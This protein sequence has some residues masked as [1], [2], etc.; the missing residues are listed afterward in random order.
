MGLLRNI[1]NIV[2]LP[3]IT[4]TLSSVAFGAV[5]TTP[6]SKSVGDALDVLAAS[7]T[8]PASLVAVNANIAALAN[9]N[10]RNRELY[11]LAPE[12]N[13]ALTETSQLTFIRGMHPVHHRFD[14]FGGYAAGVPIAPD[15]AM[16]MQVQGHMAKQ[17]PKDEFAGFHA[18]STGVEIGLEKIFEKQNKVGVD[19]SFLSSGTDPR[20]FAISENDTDSYQVDLY[21][22]YDFEALPIYIAANFSTAF[23]Q[24]HTRRHI[25]AGGAQRDSKSSYHGWQAGSR[26]ELG[27]MWGKE[28]I[29]I[30]PVVGATYVHTHF[31]NYRETSA[32]FLNL[33]VK[34][35]DTN[36]FRTTVGFRS[37]YEGGVYGDVMVMPAVYAL[38][39][40]DV[41]RANP[42]AEAS[43]IAGGPT[44]VLEGLKP[45]KNGLETGFHITLY[46]GHGF[47]YSTNYQ[48]EYRRDYR[49][50]SVWLKMQYEWA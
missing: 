44:F 43:F 46:N 16:W 27:Y 22:N 4:A 28:K 37:V 21:G 40:H 25:L 41:H 42:Q 11:N 13:G 38:W 47:N 8:A 18:D 39:T 48:Y 23:Q 3:T 33:Q 24:Y 19:I 6:I 34:L 35:T 30:A 5:G 32:D 15:L 45:R 12:L 10:T 1:F 9:Q 14:E 17:K 31:D 26:V 36:L 29:K 50:H 7:V 49:A 2:F 20:G